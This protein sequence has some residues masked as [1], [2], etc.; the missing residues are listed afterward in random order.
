MEVHM[1]DTQYRMHPDIASFSSYR[2]Y[3]GELRD[4]VAPHD[5]PVPVRGW[6]EAFNR[7]VVI[8]HVEGQESSSGVSQSNH[9]EAKCVGQ[10]CAWMMKEGMSD[11]GVLYRWQRTESA[12]HWQ[13]TSC[14]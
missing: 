11:L 14:S 3:R 4:G 2:F 7:N 9:P 6:G 1:L 5:R 8:V 12:E 13:L 10:I